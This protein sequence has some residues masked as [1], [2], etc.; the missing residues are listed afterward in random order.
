M[1][2]K[3]DAYSTPEIISFKLAETQYDF[4]QKISNIL[5]RQN[6]G[7]N[8]KNGIYR[9]DVQSIGHLG[10]GIDYEEAGWLLKI[11]KVM[12]EKAVQNITK[13][14]P[15]IFLVMLTSKVCR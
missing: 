11:N 9:R 15:L 2:T 13:F 4:V 1:L 7:R 3:K 5:F 6:S 10:E 8:C 14:F 12:A